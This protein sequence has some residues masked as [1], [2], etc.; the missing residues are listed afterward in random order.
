MTT[1]GN[2]GGNT[3]SGI[4][5]V[6]AGTLQAGANNAFSP[7]SSAVVMANASSAVLNHARPNDRRALRGGGATGGNVR[8]G[9]GTLT[10]NGGRPDAA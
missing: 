2:A 10:V 9:A 8:L 7:N 1:L 5:T 6:S 4:T 3:Y